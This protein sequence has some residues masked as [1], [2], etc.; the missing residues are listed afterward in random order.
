MKDIFTFPF[1]WNKWPSRCCFCDPNY[2][3]NSP[4]VPSGT[5]VTTHYSKCAVCYA[6]GWYLTTNH[7]FGHW[8][9]IWEVSDSTITRKKQWPVMNCCEANS[10]I[11][12]TIEFLNL[13]H[14][15]TNTSTCV[16]TV[17]KV[18]VPKWEQR[19][20]FRVIMISHSIFVTKG[21]L[22]R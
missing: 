11:H 12:I 14:S 16:R 9:N 15:E 8:R 20:M 1:S 19:A 2:R 17:L 13:C 10:L 4:E 6:E 7:L 18:T 3:V 22:L 5:K 21:A